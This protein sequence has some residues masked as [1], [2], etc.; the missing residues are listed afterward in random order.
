MTTGLN[1][2]H[3]ANW[4]AGQNYY[5]KCKDAWENENSGCAIV[6]RTS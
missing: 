1:T 2:I 3:S 4:M 6:V 5:I